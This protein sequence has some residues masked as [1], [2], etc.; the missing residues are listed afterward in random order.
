MFS[1]EEYQKRIDEANALA[2][3]IAFTF[4]GF[5]A[6]ACVL[7]LRSLMYGFQ[8]THPEEVQA[9]E[10]VFQEAVLKPEVINVPRPE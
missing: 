5:S 10:W 9:V 4:E 1:K 6:V 7:A 2:D 8:K 3:K